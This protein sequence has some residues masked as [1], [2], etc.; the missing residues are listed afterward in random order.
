MCVGIWS[1]KLGFTGSESKTCVLY[2][3][4]SIQIWPDFCGPNAYIVFLETCEKPKN[5]R[6]RDLNIS[7]FGPY[8]PK[9][10]N[11]ISQVVSV[12]FIHS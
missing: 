12:E 4:V 2:F 1:L 5:K 7:N 11:D 10:N 3:R 6:S 8:R 9:K